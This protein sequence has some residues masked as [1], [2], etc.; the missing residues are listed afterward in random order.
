MISASLA[1]YAPD[2]VVPIEDVTNTLEMPISS[3]AWIVWPR[4]PQALCLGVGFGDSWNVLL[5]HSGKPI[6]R[7]HIVANLMR[8]S[9]EKA[10]SK[11]TPNETVNSI[12]LPHP[13]H[14]H[15]F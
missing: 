12:S 8:H 5:R 6:A 13:P 11:S 7:T 3:S 14:V 10:W 9:I 1:P 4:V 15:P 2:N